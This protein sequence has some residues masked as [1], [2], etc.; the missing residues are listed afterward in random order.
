MATVTTIL[1][2]LYKEGNSETTK[3]SV[4]QEIIH[5]NVGSENYY[6]NQGLVIRLP[7]SK[8]IAIVTQPFLVEITP[9]EDGYVATSSISNV[10]EMGAT[11]RIAIINFFKSLVDELIWLQK[12]EKELSPSIQQELRLLQNYIRIV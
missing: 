10:Y 7:G 6:I 3:L 9:A 4:Q 8:V 2:R 12:H 5:A 1:P 11:H